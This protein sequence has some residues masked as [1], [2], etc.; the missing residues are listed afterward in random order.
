MKLILIIKNQIMNLI[1]INKDKYKF[2][3]DENIIKSFEKV[4]KENNIEDNTYDIS[5]YYRIDYLLK[6]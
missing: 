5:N 6:N 1:K 3:N 2:D 4:F